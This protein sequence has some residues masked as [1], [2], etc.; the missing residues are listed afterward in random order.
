MMR[1]EPGGKK[2]KVRLKKMYVWGG[3]GRMKKEDIVSIENKMRRRRKGKIGYII[4]V[5]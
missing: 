4:Y 5:Q 3:I 1:G 2:I